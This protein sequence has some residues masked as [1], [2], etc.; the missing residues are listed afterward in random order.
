MRNIAIILASGKGS[1]FGS[2]TPKQFVRLAGKPVIQYTIEAFQEANN[3]HDIIIVTRNEY[4]DFVYELVNK[5]NYSKVAKVISGGAER[6]H[7]TFA[8]LNAIT[9]KE[10]NLIIHDAVR[11]FV[12]E[13]IINKCITGLDEY[14]A[15]DVVVDAT[16]TIVQV[17]DGI[18]KNIPNRK[19]IKR[20]Q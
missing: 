5:N 2:N 17:E 19:Y 13:E 11:P 4:I 12:S 8:A 3:I 14:N 16:D 7:S 1:R 18:I 9:D 20:G 6:F 15:I 10:A